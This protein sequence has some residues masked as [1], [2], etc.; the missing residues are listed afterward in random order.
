MTNANV[1]SIVT[2]TGNGELTLKYKGG[3]QKIVVPD[4]VPIVRAVPGTRADLVP[5]EYIF[6]VAQTGADGTLTA[7]RVQVSKDGVKPPQ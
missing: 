1:E 5:G 4:G 2:R 7:T 6:T 3:T